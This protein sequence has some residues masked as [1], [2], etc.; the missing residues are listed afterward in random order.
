MGLQLNQV[1]HKV[2]FCTPPPHP[3]VYVNS[4]SQGLLYNT[5]LFPDDTSFFSIITRPA[6]SSLILNEDLLKTAHEIT[7]EKCCLIQI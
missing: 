3:L 1:F 5:E 7:Y 6:I 2:Q 4:L